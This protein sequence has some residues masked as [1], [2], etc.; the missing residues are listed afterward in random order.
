MLRFAFLVGA[1]VAALAASAVE[2][3]TFNYTGS[4]QSFLVPTTGLYTL[5]AAGAQG[6]NSSGA[7]GGLGARVSGQLELTSG[8]TL[9]VAVGGRGGPNVVVGGGGGGT[10]IYRDFSTPLAVAG[11]GGPGLAGTSGGGNYGSGP[12]SGSGGFGG[13]RGTASSGA[14]GGG[15]LSYGRSSNYANGGGGSFDL[16]SG[17]GG[18]GGD[19]GFGGGGGGGHYEGAGGGGGGG[20]FSGGRGAGPSY[21]GGLGGGSFL[22]AGATSG[23]L[24]E[25][26]NSGFGSASIDLVGGGGGGPPA[27]PE[28]SS[29]AMLMGGFGI[30]GTLLRRRR[31]RTA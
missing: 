5:V 3:A 6:G 30:I 29:W 4:V 13:Q 21:T 27:V 23:L 15:F 26:V 7:L 17:G 14:G 24:E 18:T 8:E 1:S 19:G 2:A 20:G 28:P 16:F 9:F 25:G 11:G 10:F 31:L 12:Y 22:A